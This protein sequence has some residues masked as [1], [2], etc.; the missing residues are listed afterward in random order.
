MPFALLCVALISAL[1]AS[2]ALAQRAWS[3]PVDLTPGSQSAQ[4]ARLAVD[5]AGNALSTWIQVRGQ[6]R[7]TQAARLDGTS[8]TWGFPAPLSASTTS[9]APS[10]STDVALNAAGNGMAVWVRREPGSDPALIR[11]QAARYLGASRTWQAAVNLTPT[12]AAALYPRVAVDAD[13]DAIVVWVA[14]GAATL[15]VQ[16]ARYDASDNEWSAVQTLSLDGGAIAGEPA[17]AID[18]AGHAAA[19]WARYDGTQ[20]IIQAALYD[21]ETD[22]WSAAVPLSLPGGSATGP[23]LSMTATGRT[24]VAAWRRPDSTS[25]Q[26]VQFARFDPE[27]ELWS[28]PQDLSLTGADTY[29]SDVVVD[30]TGNVTAAWTRFDGFTRAVQARR[31]DAV[32]DTWAPSSP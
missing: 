30:D 16:S 6:S 29:E 28:T 3:V 4:Q 12:L 24:I 15:V 26:I 19:A 23:H 18:E 11:V 8:G 14:Q 32:A 22:V 5:Q 7:A 9:E 10:E 27:A 21:A 17:L 1:V 2:P 20:H 25:A 13:G 31:Y